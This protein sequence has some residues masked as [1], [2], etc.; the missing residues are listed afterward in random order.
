MA[1][2]KNVKSLFE[3]SWSIV[4]N[5]KIL[6]YPNLAALATNIILFLTFIFI[7][8]LGKT[9]LSNDFKLISNVLLSWK[10]SLYFLVYLLVTILID[11]F[12][13]TMKYGLIKD[14]LLKGKTSLKQSY[15]FAKKYYFTNLGIHI[16]SYLIVLV[17]IVLLAVL[18]LTL[19][20]NSILMTITIFVPLALAYF[21]YIGIRLLFVYPVMTFEKKGAYNS[22]K[23]DFHF[24]KTHL[25][26]TFITW[27]IVIGFTI[28]IAIVK[29]N[30]EYI[31][32]I[33]YG[34]L[35]LIGLIGSIIILGTEIAVSVWEHVFIFKSYL[36]G[37]KIKKKKK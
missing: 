26:H 28:L 35:F 1:K 29:A 15:K 9:F 5:N 36:E 7:S 3:L 21:V 33:L 18:L 19:L 13:L 8:G 4:K 23:E 2:R 32:E 20:P 31:N 10:T 34:Q 14:I 12:F 11:N 27:L 25:H 30:I 24:V 22:L 6:F 17:P 37:K 16:L